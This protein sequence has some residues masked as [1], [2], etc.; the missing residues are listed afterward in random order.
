MKLLRATLCFLL[1]CEYASADGGVL[2]VDLSGAVRIG[3]ANYFA[4]QAIR[5][6]QS[7]TDQMIS[8]RWRAYLPSVGVAY[9]RT[10]TINQAETDS[11]EHDIRLT[12]EQVIYDGGR[13][14]LDLD[15]AR[16]D[17]LLAGDDFRVTYNKL[18]LEIQRAYFRVLAAR[19][20]VLL[21]ARSLE[22]ARLQLKE[23]R[24]EESLGFTTRIQVLTVASRLR[25][26]ELALDRAVHAHR[27]ALLDLKLLLNLNMTV[28]LETE[29]TIFQDY[30]LL[31]PS[32]AVEPLVEAAVRS[33]PEMKRAST[34]VHRLQKERELAED[35]WIPR[36]SLDGYAGRS[37][38]EFPVRQENWGL[39]FK[40]SF[41]IGS[42]TS[43]TTA[44]FAQSHG[45]QSQTGTNATELKFFD[46]LGHDRRVLES[47]IAL[48]EGV[49]SSRQ[50]PNQIAIEVQKA[51]DSLL[52]AWEA[53]RIGNGRAYFQFESLRLMHTRY[54]IGE[55]KRSD[56][57][58]QETELVRAQS[59]LTD[60]ISDY[61]G[62][63]HEL[64]YASGK[65]P[66]SLG[67]FQERKGRGNT[68]I[69]YLLGSS[70]RVPVRP[71][72]PPEKDPL[73][74]LDQ[75]DQTPKTDKKEEFLIDQVNP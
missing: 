30:F 29:T 2:R 12:I 35:D 72:E 34:Q 26:I 40:L 22:R 25:E 58:F 39:G 8:E 55:I 43:N 17:K 37:G 3:S 33:R 47:R 18:R 32:L 15:L 75:L 28:R 70:A 27:Q 20:K 53:I 62:A 68:L 57:L 6:R 11:I 13:R 7:V 56:I 48:G 21:N 52:E 36:F 50:L 16:I 38:P 10:R 46:D 59:D 51:Y 73:W 24:R 19:T 41:P 54:R 67:L 9:S 61:I 5:N 60:A 4:L 69:P 64:E 42:T 66:G 74:E 31:S 71:I 44:S 23:V 49:A 63:A 1:A 14:G 45:R 65:D